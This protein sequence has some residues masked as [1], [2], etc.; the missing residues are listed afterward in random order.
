MKIKR[1]KFILVKVLGT[2]LKLKKKE[3]RHN[4]NRLL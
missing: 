4:S 3:E 1:A 2:T